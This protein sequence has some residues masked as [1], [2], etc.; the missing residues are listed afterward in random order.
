MGEIKIATAFSI[1]NLEDT[2]RTILIVI[3]VSLSV[4]LLQEITVT[5]R[6]FDPGDLFVPASVLVVAL[7]VWLIRWDP[8]VRQPGDDDSG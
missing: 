4:F 8:G 3:A 1:L 6:G 2:K 7:A 5:E